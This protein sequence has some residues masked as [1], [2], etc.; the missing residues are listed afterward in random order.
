MFHTS[1]HIWKVG[2]NTNNYLYHFASK[3]L[4]NNSDKNK[5]KNN[6]IATYMNSEASLGKSSRWDKLHACLTLFIMILW[7]IY[8]ED[9][10]SRCMAAAASSRTDTKYPKT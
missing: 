9:G 7:C 10:Y 3:K 6:L 2:L 5:N 1:H 8:V 4:S